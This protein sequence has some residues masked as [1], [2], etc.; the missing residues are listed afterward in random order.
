MENIY[1]VK[2][3]KSQS[4]QAKV[5]PITWT[6]KAT[7]AQKQRN[8]LHAECPQCG[9]KIRKF[10]KNAATAPAAAEPAAPPAH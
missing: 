10:T 4:V 7:G 9:T 6:S 2:C 5:A 3:R 8:G 1:C